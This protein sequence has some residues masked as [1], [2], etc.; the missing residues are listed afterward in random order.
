MAEGRKIPRLGKAA[1]EFNVAIGTITALLKKKN[2][3]IVESPNTKLTPEM[4]DILLQEFQG[5]KLVKEEAQKIEIGTFKK[6]EESAETV[7]SEKKEHEEEPPVDDVL[8][9]KPNV[10]EHEPID[11]S[12][13]PVQPKIVGKIDI[14]PKKKPSAKKTSAS[15]K[16][17]EL[18][19]EEPVKKKTSKPA[20]E[21]EHIE[22]EVEN[23]ADNIVT[24]GKIDLDSLNKKG[25]K[26]SKKEEAKE[27]V[28]ETANDNQNQEVVETVSD[29]EN[30]EETS[31]TS[32][33]AETTI[34][35]EAETIAE[36][37]EKKVVI[38]EKVIEHIETRVEKLQAP[39]I[40]GKI[41]LPVEKAKVEK[42][43]TQN[44]NNKE[45]NEEKK[46]KTQENKTAGGKN[47]R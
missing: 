32:N 23:I 43:Q 33:E 1:G 19:V 16:K 17:E 13:E 4:Y 39:K 29:T 26:T 6:E 8:I 14:E 7:P 10:I 35:K 41:D 11:I 45:Q 44:N 36:E 5:E 30:T 24:V 38:P 15:E 2:F 3:D 46:K 40:M 20:K 28:D 27:I 21:V 25:K 37:T 42:Q 31:N 12:I 18:V 9:K 47:S 22:T 34:A